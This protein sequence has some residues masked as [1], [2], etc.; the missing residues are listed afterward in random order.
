M[1]Q[2]FMQRIKKEVRKGQMKLSSCEFLYRPVHQI[3]E[4]L[5]R[6]RGRN[7]FQWLVSHKIQVYLIKKNL[8]KIN[9][10]YQRMK[11]VKDAI[12]K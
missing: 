3:V 11:M 2:L 8:K 9:E 6:K 10:K 4:P 1:L 7:G 5:M 12:L